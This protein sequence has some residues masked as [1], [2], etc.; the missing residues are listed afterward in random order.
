MAAVGAEVLRGKDILRCP[1]FFIHRTIAGLSKADIFPKFGLDMDYVG[2]CMR[3]GGIL[4]TT[5]AADFTGAVEAT[6]ACLRLA[7][8]MPELR[9]L[10][11]LDPVEGIE[12]VLMQR[13]LLA[14]GHHLLKALAVAVECTPR[15]VLASQAALDAVLPRS[16]MSMPTLSRTLN[17]GRAA[18]SM[19]ACTNCTAGA[20]CI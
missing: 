14:V 2:T 17:P 8:H 16:A 7:L 5:L 13:M 3:E 15:E 4:A 1:G 12:P 10:M 11:V 20:L 9:Q 18:A 6:E 19:T